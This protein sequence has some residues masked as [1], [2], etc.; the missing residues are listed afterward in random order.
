MIPTDPGVLPELV[1]RVRPVHQVV[2]VEF[3]LPGCPPPAAH[4]RTVL[5]ALLAGR[6]PHLEADQIKFG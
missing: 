4:I 2:P 1:D 3:Y 5:E 6:Q